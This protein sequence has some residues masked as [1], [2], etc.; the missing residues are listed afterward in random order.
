MRA[1]AT[2]TIDSGPIALLERIVLHIRDRGQYARLR[3]GLR[4]CL[5]GT[6]L[7]SHERPISDLDLRQRRNGPGREK[8]PRAHGSEQFLGSST[9]LCGGL[10]ADRD[11]NADG[12]WSA[13]QMYLGHLMGGRGSNPQSL[14][15][16]TPM[17][18]WL[19]SATGP[20]PT[21]VRLLTT[22]PHPRFFQ[23]RRT[24]GT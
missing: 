12:L 8:P 14:R 15:R 1:R 3:W 21:L 22:L 23:S 9:R 11:L 4:S 7:A 20:I 5:C 18:R 17:A 13:E 16:R 19:I 2:K 10:I 24:G 6:G